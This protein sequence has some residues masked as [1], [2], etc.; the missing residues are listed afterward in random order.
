MLKHDQRIGGGCR[1][2]LVFAG[3][4]EDLKCLWNVDVSPEVQMESCFVAA[5]WLAVEHKRKIEDAIQT[6]SSLPSLAI[7]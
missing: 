7:I 2:V 3:E 5:S 1:R 4:Q 6:D